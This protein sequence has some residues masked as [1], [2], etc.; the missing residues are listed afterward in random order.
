MRYVR[1]QARACR[2][3]SAAWWPS[4]WGPDCWSRWWSAPGIAA[5][6]LS[7]DDVGL[8]LLENSLATA[9]GLAVLILV[10]GPVSGAHFNPVVSVVDWLLGRR[11]RTGLVRLVRSWPTG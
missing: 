9:L 3:C 10:F 2:H 8:Q 7:P 5:E 11:R 1:R 6:S 4:C